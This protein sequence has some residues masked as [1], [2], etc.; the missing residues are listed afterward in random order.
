[1]TER[2]RSASGSNSGKK[3]TRE[4]RDE[5]T[6]K[7]KDS[8]FLRQVDWSTESLALLGIQDLKTPEGSM[9]ELVL[10]GICRALSVPSMSSDV[11]C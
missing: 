8:L 5:R 9:E 3:R 10:D 2:D 6:R 7:E 1:V 4:E 11:D